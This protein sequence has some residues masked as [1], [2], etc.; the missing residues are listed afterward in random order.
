MALRHCDPWL[1]P[2][3]QQPQPP[4][5]QDPTSSSI[6][7][8]TSSPSPL[9][10]SFKS[11]FDVANNSISTRHGFQTSFQPPSLL[12][13][14]TTNNAMNNATT[15]TITP[16]YLL[17]DWLS[18]HLLIILYQHQLLSAIDTLLMIV[19]VQMDLL[20]CNFWLLSSLTYQL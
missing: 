16:Y 17:P 3:L 4:Q 1:L 11:N 7:T 14:S 13:T 6:T 20:V 5:L 19:K 18:Q 2:Q 10:L 15:Y 8:T 12:T 9:T